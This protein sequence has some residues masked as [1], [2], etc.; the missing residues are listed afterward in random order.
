M[1]HTRIVSRFASDL[2]QAR[3]LD[4]AVDVLHDAIQALGWPQVVY[5]WAP[6]DR[7][8]APGDP[9]PPPLITRNF[10]NH[11]DQSWYRHGAYDPYFHASRRSV[12]AVDWADVQGGAD[13]LSPEERD[14]MAYAS[15]WGIHKG[16]TVP[17]HVTGR[18]FAFVTA[19][20]DPSTGSWQETVTEAGATL[21]L[22]AHYFDNAVIR[23]F[24]RKQAEIENISQRELECLAWSARG[25]TVEDIAVILNLSADTVRVY[26]KR[27]NRKLNAVNRTHAVAKALYLGLID[28][29]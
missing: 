10:P 2:E 7:T 5:G 14:C 25:K 29:N 15:D 8:R 19:V 21:V 26:M 27:I 11:W 6:Q 23:L 13:L 3:S 17:I 12:T 9:L 28:L 4:Q 22:I 18:R 1:D 24:E 20:G 16:L